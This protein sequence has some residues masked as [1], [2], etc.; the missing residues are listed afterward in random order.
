MSQDKILIVDDEQ[1]ILNLFEKAFSR[2]G[3][4]I[5]TATSAEKAL[6]LLKDEDIYVM[7]LD[8][9]MPKMNGLELCRE[10]KK[11]LPMSVIYAI[12]GYASVFQ[13]AEC[14]DSG[15]DDYFKKPVNLKVL[16]KAAEDAFIKI[17]R[18]K[19]G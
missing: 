7:F 5:R 16:M 13:L 10:I 17:N 3:Y 1:A 11:D 18:W 14:R 2:A 19:K 15:F 4:D 6:D 9:N 12:T 8:L